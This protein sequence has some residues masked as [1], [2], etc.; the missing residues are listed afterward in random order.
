[1]G[2]FWVG[3]GSLDKASTADGLGHESSGAKGDQGL[4][5]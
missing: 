4:L 5:A 3:D 1:M 2:K